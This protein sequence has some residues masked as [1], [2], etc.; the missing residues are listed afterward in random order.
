[1]TQT[2]KE[3]FEKKPKRIKNVVLIK[4]NSLTC[5]KLLSRE[6]AIEQ[7]GEWYY[8]TTYAETYSRVAIFIS[9][10]TK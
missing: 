5:T 9:N 1:M 3:W 2:V 8:Q 10:N 4:G 7:Y 6:E